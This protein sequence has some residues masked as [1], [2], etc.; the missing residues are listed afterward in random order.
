MCLN[1]SIQIKLCKLP[2]SR[3]DKYGIKLP[4]ELQ[5]FHLGLAGVQARARFTG[6]RCG[7]YK[8]R[9]ADVPRKGRYLK[10]LIA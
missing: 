2:T 5:S 4:G 3:F 6:T 1:D 8:R 9:D 7:G 10:V